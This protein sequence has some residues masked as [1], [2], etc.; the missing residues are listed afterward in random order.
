MASSLSNHV[1]N[2][3]ERIHEIKCKYRYDDKK[4]GTYGIT[5]KVCDCFYE[6]TNFK[7]D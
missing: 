1:N 5:Y 2:F 7:D 6:N 3:S 4:C